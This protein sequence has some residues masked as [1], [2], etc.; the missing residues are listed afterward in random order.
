VGTSVGPEPTVHDDLV[1]PEFTA[2]PPNQLWLTDITGH[3]TGEGKLYLYAVRTPARNGSS[4]TP[5]TPE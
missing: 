1:R 5:S 2:A 3:P 4:P